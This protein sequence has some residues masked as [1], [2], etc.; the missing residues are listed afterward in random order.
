M[1]LY[2]QVSGVDGQVSAQG[3]SNWI[4]LE[5]VDLDISRHL[6]TQSGNIASREGSKPSLSEIEIKKFVDPATPDLFS[7]ALTGK[8]LNGDVVIAYTTTGSNP[9]TYLQVTL[10]DVI[11]SS[12]GLSADFLG[13]GEKQDEESKTAKNKHPIENIKLNYTKIE[14]QFTPHDKSGKAGSP[15]VASYDKETALAG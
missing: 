1:S 6:N 7:N 14:V 3:F 8:A 5:S 12:Y 13:A 10:S 15:K 2:M 4:E 11:V 9:S